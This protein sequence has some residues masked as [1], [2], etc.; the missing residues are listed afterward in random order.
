M[1]QIK[2]VRQVN[3]YDVLKSMAILLVVLGHITIL[4]TPESYPN[5]DT[6]LAQ[7]I[8]FGIYLFHMPLFMVISGAVYQL[9]KAKDKYNHFS[10]FVK[11]KLKRVIVPYFLI[12]FIVLLPALVLRYPDVC[13][14]DSETWLKILLAKDCRHLWYLLALFWIFLLQYGADCLKINLWVLLLITSAITLGLSVFAPDFKFFCL[15]MAFRKWPCFILGILLIKYQYRFSRNQM[16][17]ISMIGGVICSAI[18]YISENPYIDMI[19]SL[20]LPYFIC[21]ALVALARN[22]TLSGRSKA[23][24]RGICSYSFGIYLFHVSAIYVIKHYIDS[25]LSISAMITF[26]FIASIAVSIALTAILRKVKLG[27]MIGE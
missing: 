5:A 7:Y 4:F 18:I 3:E 1:E 6:R 23:L 10:L 9:C 13:F 11:N 17:I 12:G 20:L 16:I 19:F 8:T 24:I 25:Y 15:N 22:I 2:T 14:F 27:I 26:M 21:I